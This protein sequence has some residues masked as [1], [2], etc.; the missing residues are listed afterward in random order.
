[1]VRNKK[2][3][4]NDRRY[5]LQQNCGKRYICLTNVFR[6]AK[7]K[8]QFLHHLQTYIYL[9]TYPR[10]ISTFVDA[11]ENPELRMAVFL[12]ILNSKP[13]FATMQALANTVRLEMINQKQGPRSN[14]LA[15]FVISHLFSL[16]YHSNVLMKTR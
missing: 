15:S 11:K 16:A 10:L 3:N 14:Q 6:I 12:L 9:Q 8:K 7:K 13:N 4:I 2:N 1:M 5:K